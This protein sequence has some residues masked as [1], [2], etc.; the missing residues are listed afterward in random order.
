MAGAAGVAG[1]IAATVSA[2]DVDSSGGRGAGGDADVLFCC[3]TLFAPVAILAETAAMDASSSAGSA[4]AA[5]AVT[6]FAVEYIEASTEGLR[7]FG[8]ESSEGAFRAKGDIEA[9]T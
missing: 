5:A 4:P 7:A 3:S 1:A 2:N 9:C 8:A 6:K